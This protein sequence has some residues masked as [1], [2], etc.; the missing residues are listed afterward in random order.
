MADPTR[1]EHHDVVEW[2]GG[3]FDPD[4]FSLSDTNAR[5]QRIR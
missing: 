2:I 4:H 5:I 1:G 3:L